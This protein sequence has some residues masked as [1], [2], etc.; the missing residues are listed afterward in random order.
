MSRT[1]SD[2]Q[3]RNHQHRLGHRCGPTGKHR[4]KSAAHALHRAAE[5]LNSYDADPD[6]DQPEPAK[7]YTQ[8]KTLRAYLCQFCGGYHLTSKP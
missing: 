1:F 2:P 3:T 6:S 4:F 5:I 7:Q 8:P